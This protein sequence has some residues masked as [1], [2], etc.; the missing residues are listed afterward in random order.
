MSCQRV[1]RSLDL[2]LDSLS[3]PVPSLDFPSDCDLS[4]NEIIAR[5]QKNQEQFASKITKKK[6]AE[7][8]FWTEKHQK[9]GPKTAS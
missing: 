5:I 7:D 8:E 4:V 1:P 2:P 9:G 6:K 3:N